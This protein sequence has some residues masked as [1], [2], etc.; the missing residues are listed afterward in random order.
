MGLICALTYTLIEL[1]LGTAFTNVL[2]NLAWYE[3]LPDFVYFSFVTMT[4][5]GFGDIAPAMPITRFLV[6]LEAIVGQ[7]YLAILVA[8]LVGSK[9]SKTTLT[10]K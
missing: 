5:L 4:T 10:R 2:N 8:S 1:L 6:Y 7:F 3:L 9:I